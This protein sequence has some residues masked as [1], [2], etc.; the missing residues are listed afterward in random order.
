MYVMLLTGPM[1]QFLADK[2][3]VTY[4]PSLALVCLVSGRSWVLVL[5]GT[6]IFLC[7]MLRATFHLYH[8]FT[9][10]QIYHLLLIAQPVALQVNAFIL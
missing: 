9:Q 8:S 2:Y 5:S 1:Y 3:S 10:L 6:Q 4:G 7:F